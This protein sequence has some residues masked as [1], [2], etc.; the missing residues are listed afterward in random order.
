MELSLTKEPKISLSL[1]NRQPIVYLP[2]LTILIKFI[3]RLLVEA[4]QMQELSQTAKP[5]STQ[6]KAD[7]IF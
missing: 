1:F 7:T 6:Q 5:L 4:R 2:R 3:A